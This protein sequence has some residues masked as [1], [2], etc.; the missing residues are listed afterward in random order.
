VIQTEQTDNRS[1]GPSRPRGRRNR[2][3]DHFKRSTGSKIPP[4]RE[5]SRRVSS[6][7]A[8][9]GFAPPV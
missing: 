4:Q 5:V 6:G 9:A 7:S 2:C 1:S 8:A 3:D